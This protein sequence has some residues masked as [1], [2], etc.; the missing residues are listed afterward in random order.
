MLPQLAA[1][2]R[3]P[4]SEEAQRRFC[5]RALPRSNRY[6]AMRSVYAHDTGWMG[7]SETGATPARIVSVYRPRSS[8]EMSARLTRTAAKGGN[9]RSVDVTCRYA[10]ARGR[11]PSHHG[12]A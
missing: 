12:T 11:A 3:T 2:G 10:V 9:W 4:D 1:G 5:A 8:A 6:R 7:P